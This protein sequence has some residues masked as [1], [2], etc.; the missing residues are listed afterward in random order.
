M[1]WASDVKEF[2]ARR[3]DTPAEIL[4]YIALSFRHAPY[5]E[6]SNL[7]GKNPNTPTKVLRLLYKH[8]YTEGLIKNP[9]TPSDILHKIFNDALHWKDFSKCK[10]VLKNPNLSKKLKVQM[11]TEL[12]KIATEHNKKYSLSQF[13]GKDIWLTATLYGISHDFDVYIRLVSKVGKNE[14]E[15]N[16]INDYYFD[17]TVG[18]FNRYLEEI[19]IYTVTFYDDETSDSEIVIDSDYK[20]YTTKELK[21][22]LFGDD[23][24]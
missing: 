24:E 20:T 4:E 16:L 3:K 13:V 15:I 17:G 2:L 1:S 9:N 5:Q 22:K 19:E 21:R 8:N 11:E 12:S 14:Y 6:L 18:A 7:L 10:E 23:E